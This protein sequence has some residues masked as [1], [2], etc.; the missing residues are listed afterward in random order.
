MRCSDRAC[1][2][3]GFV[4]SADRGASRLTE[5]L[6]YVVKMMVFLPSIRWPSSLQGRGSFGSFGA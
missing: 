5:A 2:S 3:T 4:P 6:W 1:G